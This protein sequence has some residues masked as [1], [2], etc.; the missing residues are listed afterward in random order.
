MPEIP[1]PNAC[2]DRMKRVE[3]RQD[4]TERNVARLFTA[5]AVQNE[6]ATSIKADIRDL[7]DEIARTNARFDRFLRAIW[8]LVLVLIPVAASLVAIAVTN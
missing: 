4:G 1:Y 8:A 6:R 3:Q 5:S 7:L 2:L